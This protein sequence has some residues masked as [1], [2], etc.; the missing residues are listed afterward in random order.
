[1]NFRSILHID[2]SIR[3][4]QSDRMARGSHTRRLSHRFIGRWEELR[5]QD[6]I[7]YR[8]LGASP[9]QSITVDWMDAAFTP[10]DLRS[11]AHRQLLS[12]SDRL[13]AEIAGADIIVMGLPMYNFGLPASVKNWIDNLIRPG[14]TFGF[15]RNR[16][17][18]AHWPMIPGG[19]R[20]V[21]LTSRGDHGYGPGGR[22]EFC[23]HAEAALLAPLDYIGITRSETISVEF[24]AFSDDRFLASMTAAE[25]EV[26]RYCTYLAETCE[27]TSS[28][29]APSDSNNDQREPDF[30]TR[31]Y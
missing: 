21:I 23:N 14:V 3:P 15:D 13:I 19:K 1:M 25:N 18:E 8:D 17:G 10:A 12:E 9:P 20:I 4:G 5:P 28:A 30:T 22:L 24:D 31:L 29:D 2:S 6:N 26:D 27:F 16:E 11:H 7:V